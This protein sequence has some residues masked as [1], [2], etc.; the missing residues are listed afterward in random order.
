MIPR[1]PR[2]TLTDT[3]LPYASLFRSNRLILSRN[4]G[5]VEQKRQ[6]SSP[7]PTGL[8]MAETAACAPA[9]IATAVPAD[10]ARNAWRPW[11]GLAVMLTGTFLALLDVFLVNIALPDIRDPLEASFAALQFPIAPLRLP[12]PL[13]LP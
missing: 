1:P 9:P 3:L 13:F 10:P 5:T 4:P 11:A 2:S 12:P 8:S 6:A 7:G